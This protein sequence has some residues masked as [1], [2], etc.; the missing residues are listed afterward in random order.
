MKRS[1]YFVISAF[2]IL[3]SLSSCDKTNGIGSSLEGA[4]TIIKAEGKFHEVYTTGDGDKSHGSFVVDYTKKNISIEEIIED[5]EGY[6]RDPSTYTISWASGMN[7]EARHFLEDYMFFPVSF[8]FF[9]DGTVLVGG[10]LYDPEVMDF[11]G[12][13]IATVSANYRIKGGV[14]ELVAFIGDPVSFKMNKSG[15]GFTLEPTEKTMEEYNEA[16][17]K[18]TKDNLSG[19]ISH[20]FMEWTQATYQKQ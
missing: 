14:I 13:E 2:C 18:D 1:L 7:D 19:I 6:Y 4:Y 8:N 15:N 5:Y 11:W 9:N 3:F 20:M 12:D 10:A 17:A 16:F